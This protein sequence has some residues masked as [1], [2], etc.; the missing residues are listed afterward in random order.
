MKINDYFD[1]VFCINCAHRIDRWTHVLEQCRL[2]KIE[3]ERVDG[4]YIKGWGNDGC[5]A[6]HR[7]VLEKIAEGP[8]DRVLVL[9]D[10]FECIYPDTQSKFEDLITWVPD[11]WELLYLGGHYG[12]KPRARINQHVILTGYMKTTSSY[13]ITKAQAAKMAPAIAGIGPI[14]DLFSG[15]AMKDRSY[16]LQPRLM[17]QYTGYS[18]LQQREMGNAACMMDT[19]HE[20]M[21]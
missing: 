10:D 12:D 13:G 14:D 4:V 5:T 6:S 18:D 1:H 21:V 11:D 15:F 9:E 17:V 19:N 8:W 20:N 3:L 16:I 2:H 7:L